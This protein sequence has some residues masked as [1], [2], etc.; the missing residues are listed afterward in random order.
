LSLAV[1]RQHP[2]AKLKRVS[3]ADVAKEPLVILRRSEYPEYWDMVAAWLRGTKQRLRIA[4]EYDGAESLMAAV[5]AGLGVALVST[6][7]GRLYPER[8]C[9]KPLSP[10]LP[11]VCIHAGYRTSRSSDKA[12]M[13]FIE[14]L[15]SAARNLK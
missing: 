5:E 14:E 2:L 6:S 15:R 13:V 9:L 8:T 7:I 4:G 10:A 1:N 3:P 11:P 12:L